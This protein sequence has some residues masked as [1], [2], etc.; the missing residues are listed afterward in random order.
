MKQVSLS[1]FTRIL[2]VR[3][4][5]IL[6]IGTSIPI[7]MFSFNYLKDLITHTKTILM[8]QT[9]MQRIKGNVVIV[10]DLHGNLHDLIRILNVNGF[11]PQTQYLFLGD[12]V[13]RGEFSLS[14]ITLLFVLKCVYPKHI[15]LLRG[16]HEFQA[17]NKSYGFRAE[18]ERNYGTSDLWEEFN[19]CFQYLPLAAVVND[20]YFCVH[21][22][23][24]ERVHDIAQISSYRFPIN[25]EL[26]DFVLD[27]V[28]SDPTDTVELFAESP[29]GS[30]S[31][32]GPEASRKFLADNQ[33]KML[34]RGHECVD[35][36]RFDHDN[37]VLTVFSA[38]N[39]GGII[40]NQCGVAFIYA[41]KTHIVRTFP[42]LQTLQSVSALFGESDGIKPPEP[43]KSNILIDPKLITK[44]VKETP[45]NK[46]NTSDSLEH[47]SLKQRSPT[48][49]VF[50][51]TAF[52]PEFSKTKQQ[53]KI[54][55]HP[56]KSKRIK[57]SSAIAKKPNFNM[58]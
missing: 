41:N 38:S 52:S 36:I 18:I 39:Y 12:Y 58:K 5:D 27:L 37:T 7:P 32:F 13:D 29:R 26:D 51:K 57:S 49:I 10:G 45:K 22:G 50:K 15:T 42:Y 16:N 23:I 14:V 3:T 11:P 40:K 28:W 24:S 55:P 2:H 30:G 25:D 1:P 47:I 21:G 31:L 19:N 43:N 20:H 35:G 17:I 48:E 6:S 53:V 54:M 46:V 33:M 8:R 9:V 4:A 56:V 34:I 44:P